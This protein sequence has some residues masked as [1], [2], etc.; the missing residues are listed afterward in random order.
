MKKAKIMSLLLALSLTA[1]LM[2]GCGSSTETSAAAESEQTETSAEASSEAGSGETASAEESTEGETTAE[3]EE[4]FDYSGGL[5]T[6][7]LFEGVTALDYVT[8][9]EYQGIDLT[10]D[11]PEISDETIQEQIDNL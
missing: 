10:G 2:S 3:T 9:P 8:L 4:A 1:G 6:A 5:T 7:G 11:I